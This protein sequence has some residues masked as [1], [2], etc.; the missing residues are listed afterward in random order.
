MIRPGKQSESLFCVRTCRATGAP[1]GLR[2]S[3]RAL[4]KCAAWRFGSQLKLCQSGSRAR[5]LR[6]PY[7][8]ECAMRAR[9]SSRALMSDFASP[10]ANRGA[11]Q[12]EELER[13]CDMPVSFY[14]RAMPVIWPRELPGCSMANACACWCTSVAT[15]RLAKCSSVCSCPAHSLRGCGDYQRGRPGRYTP[16]TPCFLSALHIASAPYHRAW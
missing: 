11:E 16:Q 3:Y 5:R 1:V 2:A 6:A 12:L 10:F 8:V 13:I 7:T 15:F 9:R 14:A 4:A